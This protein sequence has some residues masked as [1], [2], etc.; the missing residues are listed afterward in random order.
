[1]QFTKMHGLGNDYIYFDLVSHPI[2]S[3]DWQA[4]AVRLSNRHTGIGGDGIVL[5][6]PPTH[7]DKAS[8]VC[9]F[10]MRIFNADGSEAE[11]CGN[12]SRCI[13]K[14]VFER[15]LTHKTTI[16]LETGAGMKILHLQ[17]RDGVVESVCVE[18]GTA[19]LEQGTGNKEQGVS[20]F[21][22]E[23]TE[24]HV[25]AAGETPASL[26]ASP[27]SSHFEPCLAD[28][29]IPCAL[30]PLFIVNMGN[31][32]AVVMVKGE[33]TDEMVWQTGPRIEKDSR[34]PNGTNVEFVRVENRHELTMRVWERGSGETMACG[35][36]A[37][38]SAVAAYAQGL[39]DNEITVHLLGG[40][41]RICID[42]DWNV[43]MTGGAT[44]V[45]DGE[46]D[47]F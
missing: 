40:D 13:G 32:H 33:I 3:V 29:S 42:K 34:F 15:G 35:T 39:T 5:I 24:S 14:Y 20:S 43:Q 9:D 2:S 28:N 7:R 21:D 1:M 10:R 19:T 26:A 47:V 45:F 41:L 38:A 17:V 30:P 36:G 11:M 16:T 23:G 18:M 25:T 4:L 12:A 8:E 22:Y 44:I 46:T 6:M 27:H 31:P 37:C